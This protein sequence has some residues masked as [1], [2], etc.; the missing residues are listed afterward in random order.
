MIG[1]LPSKQFNNDNDKIIE[2]KLQSIP[3]ITFVAF[4]LSLVYCSLGK[5]YH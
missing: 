2:I 3:C 5:F 4:F 1:K